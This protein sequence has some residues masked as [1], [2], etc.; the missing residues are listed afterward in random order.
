MADEGERASG[1]AAPSLQRAASAA[2]AR[3]ATYYVRRHRFRR[4]AAWLAALPLAV[5][6]GSG[7]YQAASGSGWGS[8][9]CAVVM[10]WIPVSCVQVAANAAAKGDAAAGYWGTAWFFSLFDGGGTLWHGLGS[11]RWGIA[12][13]QATCAVMVPLMLRC[14]LRIPPAPWVDW[15]AVSLDFLVNVRTGQNGRRNALVIADYKHAEQVVAAWL[16]RFGYC[17]A[18]VTGK[19]ASGHDEGIDVYSSRAVAQVKYWMKDRVRLKD[20]QRLV[21]SSEPGQRRYFFAASG[22]TEPAVKW[23]ARSGHRVGLF[24]LQQDGN[25]RALNFEAKKAIWLAPFRIPPGVLEPIPRRAWPTAAILASCLACFS[26]FLLSGA[27]L[28]ATSSAGNGNAGNAAIMGAFSAFFL[29]IALLTCGD[30]LRRLARSCSAYR[31]KRE[32]PGWRSILAGPPR[33]MHRHIDPAIPPSQFVG[34]ELGFLR[35][36]IAVSG[37]H[38]KIRLSRQLTAAWAPSR[39][40]GLHMREGQ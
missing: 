3:W 21:G 35:V 31:R 22:Y 10:A 32:W 27:Y 20:V 36:M 2:Q 29:L 9:L 30:A 24:Q 7:V 38:A 6:S 26:Y 4:R 11:G 23:A 34:Y 5:A 15:D 28:L 1:A 40:T 8:V 12:V 39:T 33:Q 19:S 14:G 18:R 37:L 25:L 17:D 13:I 16:A